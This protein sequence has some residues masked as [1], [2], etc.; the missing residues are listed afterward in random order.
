MA[1]R[2]AIFDTT[3]RDGEQA[4]GYSMNLEQKMRLAKQ[5]ELL[6]VD[7]IE[8][9]FAIA[10]PGDFESVRSIASVI[11][12]TTVAS[13][14][15][16]LVKDIDRAWEAVKEARKPRIHTFIATSDLH[17]KYKLKMDKQQAIEQAEKMV[18]YARNL[19]PEVEF[20]AED[21]MRSD[22]EYL[23]RVV[24]RTIE[25]GATI[26][27]IPDTVGYTTPDEMGG[28]ISNLMNTVAQ[29]R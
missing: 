13:L 15:R 17:L 11:D 3:L 27:N 20:S 9:G 12:H 6:G 26:I 25:M 2:V 1:D 18:R 29:H 21:A 4:P 10:S 22:R 14:S 24:E 23:A 8:A 16:A 19:S 5:L 28:M 7:V